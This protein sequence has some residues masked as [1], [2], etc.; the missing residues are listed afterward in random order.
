MIAQAAPLGAF[1]GVGIELEYMIV[2]KQGL[3]PLPIAD[4]LL[5]AASD[6]LN[7][8]V[9]RGTLGWSN[10]MVLHVIEI[11]NQ[12]PSASLETLP[13][14]FQREVRYIDS[15]LDAYGARLM[16]TAM[17]PWMN[18][19]RET[20]LWPHS[21]REL[22]QTYARIFDCNSHGWANLQSMHIN[23]PFS[24]DHEFVR[25]HAAIRLVLPILPA[26]A[27]SSPLADGHNTGYADFRMENYRI[28]A[29]SIA[30]IAGQLI[31]EPVSTC[32]EYEKTILEPM[33]RDIAEFDR[34][35]IL[36]Q[37]WLN[38]R[39]AIPRFDRSAI[40]IRVIDTQECPQA[41]LSIAAAAV[42][43]IK[44]LYDQ[45]SGALLFQQQVDTGTLASIFLACIRD[46][47]QASIDH[48]RYLELMEFPGRRCTANELWHHLIAEMQ[49]SGRGAA[50]F[51]R[52]PL[53]TILK[54]GPLARRILQ[55]VNRDESIAHLQAIY[56]QLCDCLHSGRM[57]LPQ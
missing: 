57:Y 30:S 31:P 21:N 43:V 3:S 56:R 54:H 7:G 36:Q 17:H 51:W 8:E 49:P 19:R 20:R 37:E 50:V 28:N 44:R 12:R 6:K 45:G 46:A 14:P 52:E 32:D 55:A 22:Y 41:D 5:Q 4:R 23:L 38:S 13:A 24:G 33:Y 10:E 47:D 25:L 39:G 2:D 48:A 18:P 26:L 35:G 11:K 40:E 15:I 27:A 29:Q 9:D 1:G 42:T 16:P 53:Q 34:H